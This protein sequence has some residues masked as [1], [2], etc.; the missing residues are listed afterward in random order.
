MLKQLLIATLAI[1]S[2]AATSAQA[3]ETRSVTVSV[4]GIDTRSES[5]A[6]IVLQ[7]IKTA[8]GTICGPFPSNHMDQYVQYDPCV[9]N[10]MQTTVAGLNNPRLMA[11]L[12]S[13][14][15]GAHS[16]QV[17]SAK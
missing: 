17:A 1:A 12:T 16:A 13:D 3:Q 6:R 2:V 14:K 11:L 9:R 8:A 4:A 10:V 5:G 7:R 15:A